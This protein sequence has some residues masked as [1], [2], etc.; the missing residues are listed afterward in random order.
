MHIAD[1]VLSG[2]VI[3]VSSTLALAGVGIGLSKVDYDTIPKAGILSA[4]FFVASLM[5]INIG[6][7]SA[8][9]LLTGLLGL[10]LGWTAFPALAAALLM[11]TL[12]FGYGGLTTLGANTLN[13]GAA[14]VICHALFFPFI[15]KEGGRPA[16]PFWIGFWA[17]GIGILLN[18]LFFALTLFLSDR[19]FGET[20]LAVLLA[21][22]P[23]IVIEAFVTGSA[24][25]FLKKVKPELLQKGPL[26]S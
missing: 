18:G 11:Q 1:G 23:I 26:V 9:L 2:P 13:A 22:L 5:H 6:P 15:R 4:T 24:V 20:I 10:L 19:D 7:S 21:H 17:G 25:A 14:A 12:F 16:T 3:A 8:H